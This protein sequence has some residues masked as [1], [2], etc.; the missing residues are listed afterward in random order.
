MRRVRSSGPGTEKEGDVFIA[1]EPGRDQT[2]D[3]VAV[4]CW[5]DDWSGTTV[6]GT[7]GVVDVMLIGHKSCC[8]WPLR[9]CAIGQKNIYTNDSME[10]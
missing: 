8:V 3:P 5:G 10:N 4:S 6:T 7:T 9:V 2:G 1:R